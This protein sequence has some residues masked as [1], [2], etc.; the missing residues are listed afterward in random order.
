M[1]LKGFASYH[2]ATTQAFCS[3]QLSHLQH[4]GLILEIQFEKLRELDNAF[5]WF[6]SAQPFVLTSKCGCVFETF[7]L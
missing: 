4:K 2:V 1:D 3:D 5:V 6:P 7:H